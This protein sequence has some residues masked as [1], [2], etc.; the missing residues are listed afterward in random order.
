VCHFS[1]VLITSV[2]LIACCGT[3][4]ARRD[5]EE[6]LFHHEGGVDVGDVDAKAVRLQVTTPTWA[7]KSALYYRYIYTL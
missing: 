6:F 2:V 1:S 3:A 4:A 5:G 7:A